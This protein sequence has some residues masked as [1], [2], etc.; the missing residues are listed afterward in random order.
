MLKIGLR[1]R[2]PKHDFVWEN[3]ENFD[4]N[5]MKWFF[6][7]ETDRAYYSGA[8]DS[9][10]NICLAGRHIWLCDWHCEMK[11]YFICEKN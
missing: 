2:S 7:G 4:I 9:C 10:V 1:N 11:S 3:E 6:P 5:Y 8:Y